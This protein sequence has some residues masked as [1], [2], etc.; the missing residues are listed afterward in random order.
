MYLHYDQFLQ[1]IHDFLSSLSLERNLSSKT[2]L[3]YRYDLLQLLDWLKETNAQQLDTEILTCYLRQLQSGL[4]PQSIY[5]KYVSIRQFCTYLFQEGYTQKNCFRFS[6][7][8]FKL[9]KTLPRILSKSELCSL[10]RTAE[11]EYASLSTRFRQVICIRDISILEL[12]F[13]L[14]LRISEISSLRLEDWDEVSQSVLIRG[15]GR[16]ERLLYIPSADVK[17]K[18]SAWV[19]VRGELNPSTTCLFVNKYGCPLSIYGVENVFKKYKLLSHINAQATPHYLR[20]TFATQLLNNGANLRDIQEL[21]GHASIAT[22]QIY[23]EIS[24]ERKK[25][26]MEK[27]NGRNFLF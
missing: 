21:L 9:P 27:F 8:H 20:H 2:L 19:C 15:K 22:T 24:L 1:L 5:R 4:K 13:C 3:A 10:I 7:R 16:R 17:N 11:A 14:G 23:T 12:L 18:L 6:T 25:E 26:V